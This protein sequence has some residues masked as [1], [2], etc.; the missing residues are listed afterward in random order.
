MILEG[1][2]VGL[3]LLGLGLWIIT[4]PRTEAERQARTWLGTPGEETEVGEETVE[5][6]KKLGYYLVVGGLI[7]TVWVVYLAVI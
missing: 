4:H 5:K 6:M 7:L 2:V 3:A 1:L